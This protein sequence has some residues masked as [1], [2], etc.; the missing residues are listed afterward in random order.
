MW[1]SWYDFK[2]CGSDPTISHRMLKLLLRGGAHMCAQDKDGANLLLWILHYMETEGKH[3]DLN[4]VLDVASDARFVLSLEPSHR[5]EMDTDTT[6]CKEPSASN[7][8]LDDYTEKGSGSKEDP[9]P[10]LSATRTSIFSIARKSR[11]ISAAVQEAAADGATTTPSSHGLKDTFAARIRQVNY[12]SYHWWFRVFKMTPTVL[13]C[14]QHL[15]GKTRLE[16]RMKELNPRFM[17]D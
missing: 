8:K 13:F 9:S 3:F 10:G 12:T 16:S 11:R 6:S 14:S 2:F 4:F 7:T 5:T 1:L 15:K 17:Y